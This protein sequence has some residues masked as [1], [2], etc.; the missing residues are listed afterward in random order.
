KEC[1]HQ[2]NTRTTHNNISKFSGKYKKLNKSKLIHK[3]FFSDR[4]KA[5]VNKISTSKKIN[6]TKSIIKNITKGIKFSKIKPIITNL[7]KQD[8]KFRKFFLRFNNRIKPARKNRYKHAINHLIP[9]VYEPLIL[10]KRIPK[11]KKKAKP[12]KA[13]STTVIQKKIAKSV[14]KLA[15]ASLTTGN[16]IN[17][18]NKWKPITP[19][20]G[21]ASIVAKHH[22]MQANVITT[23]EIKCPEYK[24]DTSSTQKKKKNHK[25]P[26]KT[27]SKPASYQL[28]ALWK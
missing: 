24:I 7:L 25:K 27:N 9:N 10:R 13:L 17:A 4:M 19:L 1:M 14:I 20:T 12:N 28:K 22:P 11:S 21:Y 2:I 18:Q 23:Q 5:F 8:N 6:L 16:R 3:W 15:S 26:K